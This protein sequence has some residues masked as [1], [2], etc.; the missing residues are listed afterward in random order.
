[1]CRLMDGMTVPLIL[2]QHLPT[3]H[4]MVMCLLSI[5]CTGMSPIFPMAIVDMLHRSTGHP[6]FIAVQHSLMIPVIRVTIP[7]IPVHT[8]H[9]ITQRICTRRTCQL[10][11]PT[12]IQ[13]RLTPILNQPSQ[14]TTRATQHTVKENWTVNSLTHRAMVQPHFPRSS[15]AST[16]FLIIVPA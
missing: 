11:N 12:H 13:T 4:V 7:T 2:I 15:A 3:H 16:S 10:I 14:P 8:H 1:M 9:T 5:T 6:A